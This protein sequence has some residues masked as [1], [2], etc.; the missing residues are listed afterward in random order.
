[1]CVGLQYCMFHCLLILSFKVSLLANIKSYRK[2]ATVMQVP[3]L[4]RNFR[5][6]LNQSNYK[7]KPS[8]E[9]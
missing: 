3:Y 1:M 2:F 7:S 9:Y 4:R 8:S 5:I 6:Y